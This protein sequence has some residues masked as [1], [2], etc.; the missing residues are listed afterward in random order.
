MQELLKLIQDR[1]SSR[2]PFDPERPV[3]RE[4]L[5]QILE[6]GRWAPTAHNM[7]NFE[8]AV[9][10][11]PK[12]LAAIGDIQQSASE[13][14][15]RENYQQLSFS[16]DELRRKKVGLLAAM[17]PEAWRKPD[18]K[19]A[20]GAGEQM[21]ARFGKAIAGGPTLLVILYDP[22]RR[23]PASPG[24]FLGIISL[25]CVMQNMWLMASSLGIAFHVISALSAPPV[26]KQVKAL[27]GIP[28]H[29]T[30]AFAARVGYLARPS[31][32]TLRV[33]RDVEDFAHHNRYG[34]RGLG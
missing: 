25:G 11:E 22:A 29:L 15:I 16:E 13:E 19:P 6:A 33:R 2:A 14:F 4:E 20:G 1:C 24:D 34:K 3:A 21:A 32:G 10:D 26:E 30:I 5:R 9:V 17:F 12:L 23:A 8:V 18:A 28:E 31:T 27:L 7:Q